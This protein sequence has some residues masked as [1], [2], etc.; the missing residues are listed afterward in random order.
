MKKINKTYNLYCIR[1][2]LEYD[3]NNTNNYP[4]LYVYLTVENIPTNLTYEKP[5]K[6]KKPLGAT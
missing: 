6:E 5:F 4:N 1:I 2:K 3:T